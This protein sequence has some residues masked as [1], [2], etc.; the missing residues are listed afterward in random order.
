MHRND[1]QRKLEK[2]KLGADMK[3]LD[4]HFK[5]LGK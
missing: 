4:K 2:I 3:N 5:Y 1:L